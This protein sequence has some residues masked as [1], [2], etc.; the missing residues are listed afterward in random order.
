MSPIRSEAGTLA[1]SPVLSCLWVHM[2]GDGF[3]RNQGGSVSPCVLYSRAPQLPVHARH[4]AGPCWQ[5]FSEWGP[6]LAKSGEAPRGGLFG[7][8]AQVL[9][10]ELCADGQG[11]LRWVLEKCGWGSI[12]LVSIIFLPTLRDTT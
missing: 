6:T 2:L 9:E 3:C 7:A 4:M 12:T 1:L 8:V 11:G 5:L 10:A